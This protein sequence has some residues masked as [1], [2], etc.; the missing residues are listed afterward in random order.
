MK[1]AWMFPGQG[2]QYPGM[3]RHL[4]ARYPPA[5]AILREAQAVCGLP[6]ES[7]MMWGPGEALR[8]VEV[9]EP[10]LT[11]LNIAYACYLR[12]HGLEPDA[13]AGYSAGEVAALHSRGS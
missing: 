12:E 3:G 8:K 13:V 2:S 7:V 5:V 10:A 1:M 4:I 11:A 9:L 6:L